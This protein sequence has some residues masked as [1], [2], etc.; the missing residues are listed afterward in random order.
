MYNHPL[1]PLSF[2]KR[3]ELID[4]ANVKL[5]NW[6]GVDVK[7]RQIIQAY[8]VPKRMRNGMMITDTSAKELA[9]ISRRFRK[10]KGLYR[11]DLYLK[12]YTKKDGL[13]EMTLEDT[14]IK[15]LDHAAVWFEH[16]GISSL[17]ILKKPAR[18]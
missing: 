3:Y 14:H 5:V 10:S 12:L 11:G 7:V 1:A 6:C 8:D 2:T 15:Q 16:Q 9:A 17:S 18:S 4:G 13:W